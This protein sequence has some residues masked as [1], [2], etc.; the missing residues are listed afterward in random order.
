MEIS[1]RGQE[2]LA[3]VGVV[4]VSHLGTRGADAGIRTGTCA[5]RRTHGS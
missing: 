3:L 1:A 4:S 5:A 2:R